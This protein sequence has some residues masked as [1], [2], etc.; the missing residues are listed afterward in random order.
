MFQKILEI[1]KN[2]SP[3]AILAFSFIILILMGSVLLYLPF[4]HVGKLSYINSLFTATSAV[5]VTGL[6]VVDTGTK[7]T[8][9]GQLI[10]LF[11]IQLGGLGLMTVSTVVLFLLGKSPSIKDRLV[12]QNSFTYSP[13][14]DILSLVKAILIFTFATELIGAFILGAYWQHLYP[15]SKAIFYGIFHAISAFCN[16]GFSLFTTNLEEFSANYTV[17]LT[18]ASLFILGGLGFLVIYEIFLC[19]YAK[20]TLLSLHAK[21]TLITNLYLILGGTVLFFFFEKSNVLN[22]FSLTYK[23]INSFFQAVTPRTAGFNTLPIAHLTDATLFLL[24]ILMFIGASPGS[25]GGGIKTT[26]F[27]LFLSFIKNKLQG[28]EK[29]HILFRTLPNETVQRAITV[30]SVSGILVVVCTILLLLTQRYGIPHGTG[31]SSFLEYLFEVASAFG[32]VGLSMGKTPIL[33]SWGKITLSLLMFIGRVGPL[34]VAHLVK[35][36][37]VTPPYQYSEENVMVG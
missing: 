11:L 27:A 36:E 21:L 5:C 30:V 13:T 26:T 1:P 18:I 3:P 2:L 9:W 35:I 37:K 31:N 20:K 28:R 33:N 15:L 16:A 29:V 4:A 6:T 19:L 14:K 25:C 8:F 7:F 17:V 23:I 32:T 24:I 12:L 22:G 10:V 34:T